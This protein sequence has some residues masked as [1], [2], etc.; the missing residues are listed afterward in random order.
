MARHEIERSCPRVGI[1]WRMAWRPFPFFSWS[2]WTN[3]PGGLRSAGLQD[4]WAEVTALSTHL[5]GRVQLGPWAVVHQAPSMG[6]LHQNTGMELPSSS[7]ES[8]QPGIELRVSCV[9]VR[10]YWLNRKASLAS[11]PDRNDGSS[12][13]IIWKWHPTT[14]K[15][16]AE[17]VPPF[18]LLFHYINFSVNLLSETH[19]Y[20]IK[21]NL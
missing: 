19:N 12:I 3:G 18:W 21:S 2:P 11:E 16:G 15:V 17:Y 10:F 9:Q 5:C 14:G 7:P 6:I 4:W 20:L 1:F 8:S 13:H